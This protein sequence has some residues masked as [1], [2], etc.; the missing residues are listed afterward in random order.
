MSVRSLY[1]FEA[2][3][4]IFDS[5]HTDAAP[6]TDFVARHTIVQEVL[7]NEVYLGGNPSLVSECGFGDGETGYV[8]M[9]CAMTD[10]QS[11]PLVAQYVGSAMMRILQAAGLDSA[12]REMAAAASNAAAAAS[13]SAI[14]RDS[15]K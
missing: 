4:F 1:N 5:L 15:G 9:Q 14:A 8:H 11:D 7:V 13:A 12:T 2:S 10:H 3:L 6:G